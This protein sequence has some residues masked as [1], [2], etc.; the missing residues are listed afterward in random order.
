[1]IS[2]SEAAAAALSEFL[3]AEPDAPRVVRLFVSPGA[4]SGP[5]LNMALDQVDEGD[6]TAERG[7]MTF[8]M[9]RPLADMVGDV[10]IDMEGD[11]FVIRCQ[12]PVVDPS[13]FSGCSCG[14]SG[15][16]GGNGEGGEGGEGGCGD[17][18]GGGCSCG[19]C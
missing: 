5:A 17:G 13:A 12:R 9:A 11:N 2:L 3:A 18:H 8:C 10:T 14:C 4:C 15:C 19:C 7:G 1:M 16:G 6:V